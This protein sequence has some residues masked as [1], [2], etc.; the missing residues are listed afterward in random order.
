MVREQIPRCR[1]IVG[2]EPS[3]GIRKIKPGLD[4]EERSPRLTSHHGPDLRAGEMVMA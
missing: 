2:E 3:H 1:D 4:S